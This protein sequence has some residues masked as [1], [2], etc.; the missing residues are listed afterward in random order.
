[1]TLS[2]PVWL[3]IPGY[4]LLGAGYGMMNPPA[5]Y[6]AVSA[7]PPRPGRGRGG[8]HQHGTPVRHQLRCGAR[9]RDRLFYR[10]SRGGQHVG[11]PPGGRRL[12]DGPSERLH[13]HRRAGRRRRTDSG[14]GLPPFHQ[15]PRARR[16]VGQG[17]PLTRRLRPLRPPKGR[18]HL[19]GPRLQRPRRRPP[20]RPAP[21]GPAALGNPMLC[22]INGIA[23]AAER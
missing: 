12:R 2:V 4:L 9:R 6:S 10:R 13:R 20:G 8:D 5:T 21:A 1:M 7:L 19:L 22:L 16:R 15:G 18:H 17:G 14:L 23:M 3:L 11:L